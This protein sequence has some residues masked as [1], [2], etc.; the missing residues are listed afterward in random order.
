MFI[1]SCEIGSIPVIYVNRNL[2]SLAWSAGHQSS[3]YSYYKLILQISQIFPIKN[4]LFVFMMWEG[5]I[6][7]LSF[8]PIQQLLPFRNDSLQDTEYIYWYKQRRMKVMKDEGG[9][10]NIIFHIPIDSD[11]K[12]PSDLYLFLIEVNAACFQIIGVHS[13]EGDLTHQTAL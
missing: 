13:K 7:H 8:G 10:H 1:L 4:D 9:R 3:A 2:N 11:L 6:I 5:D 12:F